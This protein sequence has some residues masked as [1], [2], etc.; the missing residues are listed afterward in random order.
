MI[1][2]AKY[3]IEVDRDA[4]VGDQLCCELAPGTFRL[5]PDGKTSVANPEGDPPKDI[6]SAAK[7]CRLEAI[8][9]FDAQTAEKVWPRL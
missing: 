9:L 6:L 1:T 7:S 5:G 8:T 4:C 3:R 2:M